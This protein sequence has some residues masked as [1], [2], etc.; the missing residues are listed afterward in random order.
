MYSERT[1]TARFRAQASALAT[2]ATRAGV[3]VAGIIGGVISMEHGLFEVLQGNTPTGGAVINAI[4]P[5]QRFWE[6]GGEMALTLIPNFLA[7]GICAMIIGVLVLVWST[8]FI[9]RRF[10]ALGFFLLQC[11]Q[12][13]LGGGI[14]FF[15]VALIMSIAATRIGRPLKWWR[16]RVPMGVRRA[17][18]SL[19]L[20]L[21]IPAVVLFCLLI[22][23]GIF[24]T[25]F[26]DPASTTKALMIFGYVTLGLMAAA[27]VSGVARD[28]ASQGVTGEG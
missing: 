18:G 6:N 2:P 9:H 4:G 11:L 28:S 26:L 14:A 5:A 22:L 27:A 7:S 8:G 17:L 10:G 20:W 23:G 25:G 15:S 19:W 21:F 12:L 1:D 3:M 13:L 16:G 24:G